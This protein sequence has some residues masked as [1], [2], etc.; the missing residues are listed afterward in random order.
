M[1]TPIVTVFIVAV[2][3]IGLG[4][5]LYDYKTRGLHENPIGIS[6]TQAEMLR[7]AR[8]VGEEK[9]NQKDYVGAIEEYK[10]AIR[11]SPKDP[12]IRND[13][14]AAYY[15]LGLKVMNPPIPEEEENGYGT[16]VDARYGDNK[17]QIREQA[18]TKLKEALD[19]TESGL[20]TVVVRNSALGKE[21]ETSNNSLGNYV[22]TEE[23]I[24]DDGTK[25]YWITI[26]KGKTKDYFID[27]EKEYLQSIELL[28]VR[29]SSG[30][31]YSAYSVASRNLGTLYF[32]MGRKKDAL[33]NW[34]RALQLEPADQDLRKLV[35]SYR[36]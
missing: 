10:R 26:I 15:S 22:H 7:R 12:Y 2:L 30:R 23:E 32:R 3:V 9:A 16:E 21:I 14:G 20:I 17:E 33:A 34:Q 36:K 29:D 5:A 13:L 19:K 1:K 11:V 4:L 31:K 8:V 25:N 18:L 35:D 27:A 28:S 6:R 24:K